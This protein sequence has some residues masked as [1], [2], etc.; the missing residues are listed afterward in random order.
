MTT[1]DPR[2]Q[3]QTYWQ[4][5]GLAG[6][7][8]SP[9]VE[10]A[11]KWVQWAMASGTSA[12]KADVVRYNLDQF[13]KAKSAAYPSQTAIGRAQLEKLDALAHG[14]WSGL[15]TGEIFRQGPNFAA[16]LVNSVFGSQLGTGSREAA[17]ARAS[18]A[19]AGAAAA[20]A[21]AGGT[22]GG[23]LN[24]FFKALPSGQSLARDASGIDSG[25][26]PMGIPIMV[27]IAGGALVLGA[28]LLSGGDR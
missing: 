19:N 28:V 10:E 3:L 15:E 6:A 24:S 11:A 16:W 7:P 26:G 21:R 27:W 12:D 2:N 25:S 18:A 14:V 4:A 22:W 5:L 17:A 1:I 13:W 8:E 9:A 20:A 23:G